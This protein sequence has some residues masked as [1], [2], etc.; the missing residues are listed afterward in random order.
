MPDQVLDVSLNSEEIEAEIYAHI[1]TGNTNTYGFGSNRFSA[2]ESAWLSRHQAQHS[3]QKANQEQ[4][5]LEYMSW[6]VIQRETQPKLYDLGEI[7]SSQIID[8]ESSNSKFFLSNSFQYQ[9]PFTIFYK[10]ILEDSQPPIA[11]HFSASSNSNPK[12]SLNELMA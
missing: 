11:D 9:A 4:F 6:D 3:P 12:A 1:G 10:V 5:M 8:K 7:I 2:P